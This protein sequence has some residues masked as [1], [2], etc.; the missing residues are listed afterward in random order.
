MLTYFMSEMCITKVYLF[1]IEIVLGGGG[2]GQCIPPTPLPQYILYGKWTLRQVL[3]IAIK[4][5]ISFLEH[6][7]GEYYSKT[8][9]SVA[10]INHILLS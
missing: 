3:Y 10:V 7:W 9:I 6:I 5:E 4:F 8:V 1:S 2:G